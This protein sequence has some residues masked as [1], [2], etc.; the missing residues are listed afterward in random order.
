MVGRSSDERG[1]WEWSELQRPGWIVDYSVYDSR[2]GKIW[3]SASHWQWGPRLHFST[4][5]GESWTEAGTPSFDDGER[6][7]EA[8]WMIEPG[9]RPGLLYAGIMPGA[10]FRSE[11]DGESWREVES[12][13]KHPSAQHWEPGAA[14]LVIH[15]ISVDPD[16]P[17]RLVVGG[18]ATGIMVSYDGGETWDVRNE[19]IFNEHF[20][21]EFQEGAPCV[22]S[23]FAHP[24]QRG[25]LW[26]QNHFGQYRS[27]DDGRSWQ[28]IGEDLP[29]VFGFPTAIDPSDPDVCYFVPHDSDQ[30]RM[31]YNGSLAVYRTSDAGESWDRLSEGLPQTGFYHTV[32]RHA[33]GQ[34]GGDP[35]GLYFGSSGG[36]LYGSIDG[37]ER[38]SLLRE[39]LAPVTAVRAWALSDTDSH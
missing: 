9:G 23:L 34:D 11:D 22:H 12:L 18:S 10:L 24:L 3:C 36:E 20:P 29:G 1:E 7:V 2:S 13:S 6:S 15:H 39:H 19:G 27:D 32:Y 26:Q 21:A 25:R 8:I 14:G 35:L 5:W 17:D 38:W 31:P 33:L 37:G 4:D 28:T 16:D 30:A